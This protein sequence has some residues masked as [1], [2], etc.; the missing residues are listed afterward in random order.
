[1]PVLSTFSLFP[2]FPRS[3]HKHGA[4]CWVSVSAFTSC[5]SL[6]SAFRYKKTLT[7]FLWGRTDGI[8]CIYDYVS[9]VTITLMHCSLKRNNSIDRLSSA[10][11]VLSYIH[12][13][14][15]PPLAPAIPLL[16][17]SHLATSSKENISIFL[18]LTSRLGR[19]IYTSLATLCFNESI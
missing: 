10:H 4:F 11:S 1:M 8:N 18:R 6:N 9:S 13:D 14:D 17:R 12:W 2:F 5:L 16:P 3:P 7:L 19:H 15:H